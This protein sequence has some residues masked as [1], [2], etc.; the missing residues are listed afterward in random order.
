MAARSWGPWTAPAARAVDVGGVAADCA[1]IA[2]D[3]ELALLGDWDDT[4]AAC[5]GNWL[6]D[7]WPVAAPKLEIEWARV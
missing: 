4:A 2:R 6:D 5:G 7:G 1:S 3:G